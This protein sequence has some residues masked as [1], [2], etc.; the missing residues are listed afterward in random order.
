L[1]KPPSKFYNIEIESTYSSLLNPANFDLLIFRY[2][3]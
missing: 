3:N 2:S 1:D